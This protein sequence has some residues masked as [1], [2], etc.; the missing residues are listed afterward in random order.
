MS[1]DFYT[2][3]GEIND[4]YATQTVDGTSNSYLYFTMD[5][6]TYFDVNYSSYLRE[7]QP[8]G[9][10]NKDTYLALIDS[11]YVQYQMNAMLPYTKATLYSLQLFNLSTSTW[12]TVD[13]GTLS[14][15]YTQGKAAIAGMGTIYLTTVFCL[16]ELV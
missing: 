15:A 10:Y 12:D 11:P 13:S 6:A 7:V 14:V 4:L 9:L 5:V 1:S 2:K 16:P 8:D 3:T